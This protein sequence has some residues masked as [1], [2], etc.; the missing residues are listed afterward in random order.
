MIII[1]CSRKKYF[2]LNNGL[3]LT[4]D[5]CHNENIFHSVHHLFING[6][7]I[8]KNCLYRFPNATK[9]TID[10]E[11]WNWFSISVWRII[12]LTQL[13][14]LIITSRYYI[15]DGLIDILQ[16]TCNLHTLIIESQQ[17]NVEHVRFSRYETFE[18]ISSQNKIK[19]LS[20]KYGCTLETIRLFTNL[21]PQLQHLTIGTSIKSLEPIIRYLV[22]RNNNLTCQLFSLCI[23]ELNFISI[24]KLKNIIQ[25]IINVYSIKVCNR[26]VYIWW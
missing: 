5:P 24:D 15:V 4:K 12:S 1:L 14:H 10:G 26:D 20:I 8:S 17:H 3:D 13:T 16:F 11:Q 22:S 23:L 9:L 21:C 6:E 19:Y 7:N 18:L 25:S 2:I